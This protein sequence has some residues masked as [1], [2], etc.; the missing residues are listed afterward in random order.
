MVPGHA[1]LA[2]ADSCKRRQRANVDSLR[3]A[4]L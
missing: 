3:V 4:H 2:L 1:L